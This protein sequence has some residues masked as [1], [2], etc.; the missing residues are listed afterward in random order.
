MS[1]ETRLDMLEKRMDQLEKELHDL[2]GFV[3]EIDNRLKKAGAYR[4]RYAI[5]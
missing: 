1:L 4:S 2:K 5:K 3:T